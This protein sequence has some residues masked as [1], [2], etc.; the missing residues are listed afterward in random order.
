MAVQRATV[1]AT[2]A[3]DTM[4]SASAAGSRGPRDESAIAAAAT[5]VAPKEVAAYQP[6]RRRR[7]D[8]RVS[9]DAWYR[10]NS[11]VPKYTTFHTPSAHGAGVSS[12]LA[13][14]PLCRV[15]RR[16]SDRSG[17]ISWVMA[18]TLVATTRCMSSSGV[19]SSPGCTYTLLLY[20]GH[21]G[22]VSVT[23]PTL[24]RQAVHAPGVLRAQLR[25]GGAVHAAAGG[26]APIGGVQRRALRR[27]A[28]RHRVHQLLSL[29]LLRRRS[30]GRWF[31]AARPLCRGWARRYGHPVPRLGLRSRRG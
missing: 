27:R 8:S 2:V 21:H 28:Q 29:Q 11:T 3:A 5:L 23:L 30:R 7:R 6:T 4:E 18:S 20:L 12:V 25:L 26:I 15:L 17:L 31:G 22:R 24:S 14:V 10:A 16:A 13:P 9:R 19:G 1:Q